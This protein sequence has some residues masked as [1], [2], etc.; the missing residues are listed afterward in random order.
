[1][2]CVYEKL[3]LLQIELKKLNKKDFSAISARVE[4]SQCLLDS[5]QNKLGI[6][7][8]DS[9]TQKE[10]KIAY[11]QFLTLSRA[12]ESLAR[13]KS[14][15]NW[16]K[17]GDQCTS[18]FFKSVN[19]NRNKTKITSL[20]LDDSSITHDDVVIKDT[21]VNFYTNLLGRPHNGYDR[22]NQL[23]NMRLTSSQSLEMIQE[24]S[25]I[26]IR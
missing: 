13:Q 6:N 9:A 15:I 12:E 26:E 3:K 1:M 22:V 5:L 2:F 8:A 19:D 25:N 20:V 21:F 24:V 10:E 11:N 18:F 7:P 16:L 23:I 17:L 14:R 4:Q